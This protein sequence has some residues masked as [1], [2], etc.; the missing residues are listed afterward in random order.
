MSIPT[1]TRGALR[2]R[3]DHWCARCGLEYANN[4]HHRK[5]LSQ[6][7]QD[8]L[9]NL[10]LLCGSGTTGCH[11]WVTEHP[12]EAYTNGWSVRRNDNPATTPVLYRGARVLLDDLG[13]M[14]EAAA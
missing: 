4:A 6:G 5:N 11:G 7:G 8:V 14:Q 10:L 9:S 1:R 12:L 13:N 2:Q 3:E